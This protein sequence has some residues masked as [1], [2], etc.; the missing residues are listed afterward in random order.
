MKKC[1]LVTWRTSYI[2]I[3]ESSE[4]LTESTNNSLTFPTQIIMSRDV[5]WQTFSFCHRRLPSKE[6]MWKCL[7]K[8][9]I[10]LIVDALSELPNC[11]ENFISRATT[12]YSII[13]VSR[14]SRTHAFRTTKLRDV[15][16]QAFIQSTWFLNGQEGKLVC[17]CEVYF[18]RV[19]WAYRALMLRTPISFIHAYWGCLPG[20]VAM[21]RTCLLMYLPSYETIRRSC[22]VTMHFNR[23]RLAF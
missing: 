23:L 1:Y 9:T 8:Q 13:N 20:E 18:G 16:W 19:T 6:G 14:A 15:F 11:E 3:E 17:N 12:F 2:N 10:H 5:L 22:L 4:L 21:E 7:I